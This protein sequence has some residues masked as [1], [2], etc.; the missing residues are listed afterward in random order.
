MDGDS[1][2]EPGFLKLSRSLPYRWFG[3]TLRNHTRAL[4]LGTQKKGWYIWY[5][6]LDQRLVMW[7]SL[8]GI[9]SAL[10]LSFVSDTQQWKTCDQLR[11]CISCRSSHIRKLEQME[12][13][14][15][16]L[17]AHLIPFSD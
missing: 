8:V 9:F 3:N 6:I 5:A 4:A 11:L 13:V 7:T 2:M 15:S 14:M 12:A 16:G 17:H 10:I 1:Y